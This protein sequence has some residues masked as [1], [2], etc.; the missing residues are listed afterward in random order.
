MQPDVHHLNPFAPAIFFNGLVVC[1][2]E[3]GELI[4]LGAPGSLIKKTFIV[5]KVC[6]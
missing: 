2:Y 5:V 4:T 1:S 3:Y 6:N